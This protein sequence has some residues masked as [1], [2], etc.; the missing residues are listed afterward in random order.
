MHFIISID[1]STGIVVLKS[2]KVFICFNKT[3]AILIKEIRD[4]SLE[5]DKSVVYK[6]G[7]TKYYSFNIVFRL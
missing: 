3:N 7:K 5:T 1:S 6:I 4:V 2:K